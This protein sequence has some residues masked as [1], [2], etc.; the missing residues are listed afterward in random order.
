M[1]VIYI[2]KTEVYEKQKIRFTE[3][4]RQLRKEFHLHFDIVCIHVDR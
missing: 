2:Y 1:C 4:V 3:V